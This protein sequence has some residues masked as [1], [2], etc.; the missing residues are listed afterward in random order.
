MSTEEGAAFRE[1]VRDLVSRHLRKDS[2]ELI[3]SFERFV[4]DDTAAA[5]EPQLA[6]LVELGDGAE[7]TRLAPS[8]NLDSTATEELKLIALFYDEEIKNVAISHGVLEEVVRS[9]CLSAY[10]LPKLGE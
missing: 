2:I 4:P 8:F 5:P 9:H 1:V 7:V 10:P 3:E 6:R